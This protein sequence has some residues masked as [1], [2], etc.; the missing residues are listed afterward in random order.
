MTKRCSIVAVGLSLWKQ[1]DGVIISAE[2][3]LVMTIAVLAMIVGLDSASDAV[4]NELNDVAG[5]FGAVNQSFEFHG[6]AHP[7][8]D[9]G[10]HAIASGSSFADHEDHCDCVPL[11]GSIG[12]IKAPEKCE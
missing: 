2:L 5:A 4:N 1:E 11:D 8:R 7:C 10:D 9:G 12:H 6:I 3:V